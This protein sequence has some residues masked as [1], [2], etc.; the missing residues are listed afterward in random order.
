MYVFGAFLLLIHI[1]GTHSLEELV[2]EGNTLNLQCGDPN[3]ALY[4]DDASWSYDM[5]DYRNYFMPKA[6]LRNYHLVWGKAVGM[7][8]YDST[9]TVRGMCHGKKSCAVVADRQNFSDE[10]V[11]WMELKVKYSCHPCNERHKRSIQGIFNVD[12]ICDFT[13]VLPGRFSSTGCPNN[14]F[15]AKHVCKTCRRPEPH[16]LL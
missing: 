12:Y 9:A 1:C 11:Y 10:C 4:I 16:S 14:R 5:G 8:V 3:T 13:E 7:C 6:L 2:Y 15:E